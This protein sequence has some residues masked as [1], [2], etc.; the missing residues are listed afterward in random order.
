MF[1]NNLKWVEKQSP[2]F[3]YLVYN[4]MELFFKKKISGKQSLKI[5]YT[6]F[7][8]QIQFS[9][10]SFFLMLPNTGKHWNYLYTI[11]FIKTNRLLKGELKK[12]HVL[13]LSLTYIYIYI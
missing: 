13:Y 7:V 4:E 9:F 12:Q 2:N 1:D 10:D 11:F 3:P 5:S 8:D 6:F